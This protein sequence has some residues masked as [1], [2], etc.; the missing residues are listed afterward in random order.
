MKQCGCH[1]TPMAITTRP[2]IVRPHPP[3]CMSPPRWT[4]C[5]LC[6]STFWRTSSGPGSGA[7]SWIDSTMFGGAPLGG[8]GAM[9]MDGAD[10]TEMDG[11]SSTAILG[12]PRA[13]AGDA[14][15][16]ATDGMP[17]DGARTSMA[18]ADGALTEMRG[19]GGDATE[20]AGT[21][22]PGA[23]GRSLDMLD[24]RLR[25]GAPFLDSGRAGGGGASSRSKSRPAV[26]RTASFSSSDSTRSCTYCRGG[27][28]R[29]GTLLGHGF[30]DAAGAEEPW[31]ASAMRMIKDCRCGDCWLCAWNCCDCGRAGWGWGR[32]G[33]GWDCRRCA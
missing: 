24:A 32:S 11:A 7:S 25:A 30:C 15:R 20:I 18:G 2:S 9:L 19:L 6:T 8:A 3:H 31:A 5:S 33:G 21:D 29:G 14:A 17:G 13:G 10:D 4:G 16:T 27:R 1:R 22:G 12:T 26:P 28:G 23:G